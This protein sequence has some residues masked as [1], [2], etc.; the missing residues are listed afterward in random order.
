[1]VIRVK[2]LESEK[3]ETEMISVD[4]N[5]VKPE[6]VDIHS[7]VSNDDDIKLDGSI[8]VEMEREVYNKMMTYTK[9]TDEEIGGI[10]YVEKV[11]D[12]HFKI[13]DIYL[14]KQIVSSAR[15]VCDIDDQCRIMQ[16]LMDEGKNPGNLK[17]WWHSHNTM[18]TFW[19]GQDEHTGFISAC[20]YFISIVVNHKMELR[21]KVDIC[22]PINIAIDNV[23]VVIVNSTPNKEIIEKCKEEVKDR[24]MEKCTVVHNSTKKTS[25]GSIGFGL[26]GRMGGQEVFDLE[27]WRKDNGV[28][29][30]DVNSE[31][32]EDVPFEA[33]FGNFF[34]WDKY[35]FTWDA[36]ALQYNV[37]D[38]NGYNLNDEELKA[39]DME[40]Y[41]Y[42]RPFAEDSESGFVN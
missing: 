35:N 2:E 31:I 24:V 8:T 18:G 23:P 33:P 17:M 29:D 16:E 5:D 22:D 32:V 39:I 27:Q 11:D 40:M 36:K 26:H 21:C 25:R 15:C 3:E 9:L 37:S 41:N 6:D 10:G 30:D 20:D 42:A 1:M 19:S 38:G 28:D 7:V 34:V 13:T 12:N 4:V 14:P